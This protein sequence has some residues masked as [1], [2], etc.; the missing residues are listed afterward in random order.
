MCDTEGS[1][2]ETT[3]GRPKSNMTPRSGNIAKWMAENV[4]EI[5]R[6]SRD[7]AIDGGSGY[8]MGG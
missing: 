3:R 1:A 7:R 4:E 6:D 8:C 5:M 2:W